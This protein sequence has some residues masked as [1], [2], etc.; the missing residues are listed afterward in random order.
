MSSHNGDGR[1]FNDRFAETTPLSRIKI[2]PIRWLVPR[3]IPLGALTVTAG[4]PGLGKSTFTSANLSA[5]VT[6]GNTD[7][8]LAGAPADVLIISAEDTFPHVIAPRLIAEGADLER[9]HRFTVREDGYETLLGLPD[10]MPLLEDRLVELKEAGHPV[11]LVIVDPIGAF[12]S[13]N[14]DSYKDASVR[15]A[16]APLAQVAEISGLAAMAI[17]HLNKDQAQRLVSRV[18]GSVGFVG[19]ARSVLAF[20]RDPDDPDGEHGRR[21]VIVHAKTNW[22]DYAPTLAAHIEGVQ[23]EAAGDPDPVIVETSR[24]V[25]DGEVAIGVEDISGTVDRGGAT[26]QETEEAIAAQVADGPQPSRHVKKAVVAELG[27]GAR[28]VERAAGRMHD[29]GELTIERVGFPSHTVWTL[30]PPLLTPTGPSE[31]GMSG[32]P[33]IPEPNGSGAEGQSRYPRGGARLAV[34]TVLRAVGGSAPARQVKEAVSDELDCSERT[35][36]R[37]AAHMEAIGELMASLSGFPASATWT[38]AD[39]PS[40]PCPD[41]ARCR[42]RHRHP[43]GP[44]DCARNHPVPAARQ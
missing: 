26:P 17:M 2:E 7:G 10:D 31:S 28:T 1:R 19:A 6:R 42:F 21:R 37:A 9:V 33:R 22:G 20:A 24:L 18:I 16:L 36:E 15:R 29:A 39:D 44:W 35:V 41:P 25:I 34:A 12:L 11:A 38:L 23:V 5:Q 13:D 3:R 14:V 40:V 43:T 4:E 27:C 8:V 32:A 30:A